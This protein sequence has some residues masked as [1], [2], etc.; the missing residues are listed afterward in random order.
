MPAPI[1]YLIIVT[2]TGEQLGELTQRLVEGKFYFTHIESSGGIIQKATANLLIG[3]A[4]ERREALMDIFQKC[5]QRR[6][7]YIP[8]RMEP[9]SYQSHPVMIEAEIGGADIYT[10]EIE[11][12]E[13]F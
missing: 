5:C 11:R 6:R 12:F 2:V 4:H 7:T 13:Q 9:A 3:I 10:F 8:A 1:D